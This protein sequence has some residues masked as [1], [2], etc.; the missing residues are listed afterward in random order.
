MFQ[1]SNQ[2][3]L[4]QTEEE[5]IAGISNITSQISRQERMLRD[6]LYKQNPNRFEDRVYRS[7]D[8]CRMRGSCLRESQK[9]LSDVRLGVIM[10]MIPGVDLKRSVT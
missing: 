2:V 10:G 5:I 4:G 3:T 1:I 9:L 6:E 7:W 8:C